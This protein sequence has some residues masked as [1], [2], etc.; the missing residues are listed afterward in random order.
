MAL[1]WKR[2]PITALM[3]CKLN[4]NVLRD[5]VVSFETCLW[6]NESQANPCVTCI[7]ETIRNDYKS[8]TL[9]ASCT[10]LQIRSQL[11]TTLNYISEHF[12]LDRYPS[13]SK[14][15]RLTILYRPLIS[16][17]TLHTIGSPGE[18]AI[19][20]AHGSSKLRHGY[21][22]LDFLRLLGLLCLRCWHRKR[23]FNTRTHV[24]L[25]TPQSIPSWRQYHC[26]QRYCLW[27]QW[28]IHRAGPNSL[29]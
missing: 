12:S 10:A 25:H 21:H 28:C 7:I 17:P 27:P 24:N 9:P 3:P 22:D 5:P 29:L 8:A 19:S 15:S 18:L 4:H 11:P 2:R 1:V 6:I 13:T 14:R 16:L 23:V 26:L 20:S